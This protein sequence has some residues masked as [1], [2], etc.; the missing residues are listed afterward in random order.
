MISAKSKTEENHL[1][2]VLADIRRATGVGSKPMLS[3]LADEIVYK[4]SQ[5]IAEAKDLAI[6]HAA[7][8][9]SDAMN[10]KRSKDLNSIYM[11]ILDLRPRKKR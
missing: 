6:K 3:E 7:K 2:C 5:M 10:G 8:I 11:E 9:V 4:R 1:L